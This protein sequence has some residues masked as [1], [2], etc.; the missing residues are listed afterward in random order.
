MD[1]VRLPTNCVVQA[2]L[3]QAALVAVRKVVM[4]HLKI[5]LPFVEC[6][7]SLSKFRVTVVC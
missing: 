2:M 3:A 7:F 5:P 4:N 6:L 1:E